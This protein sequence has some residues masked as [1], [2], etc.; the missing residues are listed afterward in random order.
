MREG[1]GVVLFDDCTDKITKK[2]HYFGPVNI[3]KLHIKLMDDGKGLRSYCYITDALNMLL[4]IMLQGKDVLY[5]VGG[6]ETVSIYEMAQLVA[7]FCGATC[8]AGSGK[9][10][11]DAPDIVKLDVSK[12]C[13]EF[14]INKFIP[15]KEGLKRTID[16]NLNLIRRA[17]HG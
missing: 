16:W 6:M 14:K 3:D 10:M 7:R 5:N 11:K 1:K 4:K 12:V 13:N 17:S 15:F 2:R 8:E 9:G